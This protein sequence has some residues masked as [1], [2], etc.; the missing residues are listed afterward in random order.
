MMVHHQ[1]IDFHFIVLQNEFYIL[2]YILNISVIQ[3]IHVKKQ[4]YVWQ[5]LR[6]W[7][8][9]EEL[10]IQRYIVCLWVHR[11]VW[12]NHHYCY[13][14]LNVLSESRVS[15][16]QQHLPPLSFLNTKC[17]HVCLVTLGYFLN[18]YGLKLI[19]PSSSCNDRFLFKNQAI[20]SNYILHFTLQKAFHMMKLMNN[21]EF[22]IKL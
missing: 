12:C 19:T 7:L 10:E 20:I 17:I 14:K 1:K 15:T 8:F 5:F 18:K 22:F 21:L 6:Q 2:Q 9:Y 3:R 16:S 11:Q 13:Q 4:L